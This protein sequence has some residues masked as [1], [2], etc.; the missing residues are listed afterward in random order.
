MSDDQVEYVSYGGD[1]DSQALSVFKPSICGSCDARWSDVN[2]TGDWRCPR[3]AT[4]AKAL[5][6]QP[7]DQFIYDTHNRRRR[8]RIP[9]EGGP[10]EEEELDADLH[11]W[12]SADVNRSGDRL[13]RISTWSIIVM[14]AFI[15]G[16]A[17]GSW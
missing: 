2:D 3:C 16:M 5:A 14:L 1:D 17:V 15:L 8:F 6:D 10:I 9:P 12:I 4:E 13:T 11:M 7:R